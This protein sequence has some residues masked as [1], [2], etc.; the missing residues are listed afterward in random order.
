MSPPLDM[1][2]AISANF[3]RFELV[4]NLKTA[5]DIRHEVPKGLLP[6]AVEVIEW[7]NQ[8]RSLAQSRH[9]DALN[10]CPLSGVKQ[11]FIGHPMSAFDPKRT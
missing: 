3:L 2:I 10:K 1:P 6:R 4:V 8:C 9:P 11:T 5:K 7:A